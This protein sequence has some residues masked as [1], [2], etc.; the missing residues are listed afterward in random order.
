MCTVPASS[1]ACANEFGCPLGA[2][3]VPTGQAAGELSRA[4]V[5]SALSLAVGLIFPVAS[6]QRSGH[7]LVEH[8]GH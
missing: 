1:E 4:G 2:S 6:V 3:R 8:L 5:E 7:D